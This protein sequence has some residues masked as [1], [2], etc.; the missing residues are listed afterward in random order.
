M[1]TESAADRKQR[2]L[3][4]AA[5]ERYLVQRIEEIAKTGTRSGPESMASELEKL[6]TIVW[7]DLTTFS[8]TGYVKMVTYA[9]KKVRQYEEKMA[10]LQE[11]VE[12]YKGKALRIEGKDPMHAVWL[13]ARADAVIAAM[14]LRQE[15]LPYDIFDARQM[16]G[17]RE[18]RLTSVVKP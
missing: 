8:D 3:Q 14:R 15:N 11:Q 6:M 17:A 1:T 10:H 12:Q 9:A 16:R 4:T 13:L 18:S 7:G 5:G 2:L